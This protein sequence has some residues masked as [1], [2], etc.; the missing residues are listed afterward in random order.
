[1]MKKEKNKSRFFKI[2]SLLILLSIFGILIY[3]A[4][5]YI[6]NKNNE[7]LVNEFFTTYAH[8]DEEVIKNN[9]TTSNEINY[10][11]ILEIPKINL[12][13]GFLSLGDKNNNVNKNIEVLKNSTMPDEDKS[14]LA[15]AGHSGNGKRSYFKYLY[16]LN[17]NDLIY[18]YYKGIKYTYEI[19]SKYDVLKDGDIEV[20]R[21]NNKMLVLTT[22]SQT[23]RTKQIVIVSNLIN[24]EIF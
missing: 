12:K 8:K 11:G 3:Y 23:D 5:I 14:L 7:N 18:V 9:N 21:S 17:T 20:I 13:R 2:G 4:N 19:V 6:S 22:C 24:Q 10:I 15:I 16:K 1:M